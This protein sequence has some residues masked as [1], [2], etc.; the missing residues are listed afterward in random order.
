MVIEVQKVS[1]TE[2][3]LVSK[4]TIDSGWHLYAQDVP[5]DGPVPTSFVYTNENKFTF[6][7]KT[8][9]DKGHVVDDP[10][11]GMTIKYFEDEAEFK[12]TIKLKDTSVSEIKGEVEFMVCDDKTCLPPTYVDLVFKLDNATKAFAKGS[13]LASLV[14]NNK[15]KLQKIRLY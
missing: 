7:G 6:E 8:K 15:R 12:Q 9:E 5:E 11:F 14:N 13:K 4:A 1:D 3:I 2:Y 10:V